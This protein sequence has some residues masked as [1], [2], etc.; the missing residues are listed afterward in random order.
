MK[1]LNNLSILYFIRKY[2]DLD[3]ITPI[4]YSILEK[5]NTL[6]L[7]SLN[8][9]QN[10]ENDYRVKLLKSKFQ[11][12]KFIDYES[13]FKLNFLEKLK[14]KINL[15][16]KNIKTVYYFFLLLNFFL[17]KV[18]INF[19]PK[20]KN[21]ADKFFDIVIFDHFNPKNFTLFS[22]LLIKLKNDKNKILCL[23]H[24]FLLYKNPDSFN[25]I[26]DDFKNIELFVDKIFIT[27]INWYKL[28]KK[29]ILNKKKL[30]LIGPLRFTNWW[31]KI[32]E[33]KLITK[34]NDKNDKIDILILGSERSRFIDIVKFQKMID[35]FDNYKK[36]K[37]VF[38]PP[39]RTNKV[40]FVKLPNFINISRKH[41]LE[42][43]EASDTVIANN[44]SVILDVLLRKKTYIS[45]RFLRPKNKK[46]DLIHETI[47]SCYVAN[48]IDEFEKMIHN[49]QLLTNSFLIN[50]KKL[51][52]KYIYD[53]KL[54]IKKLL[55]IF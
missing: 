36:L 44:T 17:K 7:C 22:K 16:Y 1:N 37:I 20:F 30:V 40:K 27:N 52:K 12:V 13:F 11:N 55:S 3:H 8:T 54:T 25:L 31:K 6:Y 47:K 41:T 9:H 18:N 45:P 42:L 28:I 14:F 26:L 24:G 21:I 50:K 19:N 4:L 53:H 39:T 43:I 23:P 2:N 5:K 33:K 49:R 46:Y 10:F 51:F 35:I 15:N 32:I 38:K 48:T 29:K 34:K